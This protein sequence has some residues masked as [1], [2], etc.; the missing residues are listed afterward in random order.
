MIEGSEK[1]GTVRMEQAVSLT[2]EEE[3]ED[4]DEDRR[5]RYVH[6][7]E[8]FNI[9]KALV[10]YMYVCFPSASD[11]FHYLQ[12]EPLKLTKSTDRNSFFV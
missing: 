12:Q 10:R 7:N 9:R 5:R 2:H 6:R 3:E 1:D 8:R 11:I 4:D